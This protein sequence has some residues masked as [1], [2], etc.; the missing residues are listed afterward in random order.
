[1]PSNGHCADVSIILKRRARCG[2]DVTQNEIRS[3]RVVFYLFF[4]FTFVLPMVDIHYTS[5]IATGGIGNITFLHC[6]TSNH[7]AFIVYLQRVVNN[8]ASNV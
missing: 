8:V 7:H 1:M 4:F 5:D 3:F 6:S 2:R